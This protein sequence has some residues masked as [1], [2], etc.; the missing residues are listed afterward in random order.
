MGGL[1]IRAALPHLSKY[2]DLMYTYFSLSSPHL[3]YMYS[4]SKL[5]GAG[6]WFLK[7]WK[8]AE[9]LK[10][11]SM[12]DE[13]VP[14]DTFIFKLSKLEGL[15]WFKNVG[16]ISSFEDQYAPYDS[17]RIQIHDQAREDGKQGKTYAKMA[18]NILNDLPLQNLY[19]IDVNF[20]I[21]SK[22]MDSLIGRTAHIQFLENEQFM[23]ML[24]YR[25]LEFFE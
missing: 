13:S 20:M 18:R 15:K 3:G 9:S 14:E 7:Q 19:R 16:L 1:I 17:A 22:T 4:S 11:L 6:M 24:I 5:V 12:T 21:T 23:R 8:G 10:Q 25:F 2:K